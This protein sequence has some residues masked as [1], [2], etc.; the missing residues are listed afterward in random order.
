MSEK[1]SKPRR[2]GRRAGVFASLAAVAS[3]LVTSVAAAPAQGATQT[4]WIPLRCALAGSIPVAVGASLTATVPNTVAPGGTFNIT[5]TT[6]EVIFPGTAQQSAAVFGANAIQGIVT[7]FQTHLVNA[8]SAFVTTAGGNPAQSS[9]TQ[10]NAVGA[11]QPPNQ[12][13]VAG[14]SGPRINGGDTSRG[15]FLP[16]TPAE[17]FSFGDVP[18]DTTGNTGNRYGPAP[19]VGGGAAPGAGTPD[20]VPDLGPLTVTG[21]AG[22]DVTIS[23]TNPGGTP[24]VGAGI[25]QPRV[26]A[27]AIS[28][29]QGGSPGTYT[30]QL[31]ADCAFDNRAPDTTV[32]EPGGDEVGDDGS[33]PKPDPTWVDAFTIPIEDVTPPEDGVGTASARGTDPDAIATVPGTGSFPVSAQF[34]AVTNCDE[35]A[36]TR[37]FIAHVQTPLNVTITR[38]STQTST[39]HSEG[40]TSVNEGTGTAN[41][42]GAITDT[43]TFTWRFEESP[44]TVDIDGTTTGGAELH[45]SGAPQPLSGTPGGV[46]VFGTLPWPAGGG[47]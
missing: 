42:T 30:T 47:V 24:L 10:F 12:P 6:T 46:W 33:V 39:C 40:G 18:A 17:S 23:N 16:A 45:I 44:D 13:A 5:G 4:A 36:N 22:Q 1:L 19:G 20:T 27:N 26:V 8:T 38:T 2:R 37:P 3:I 25:N 14:P 32:N 28:F 9:P 31:P 43:A 21:A 41:V 35:N 15:G 29:H 7:Q 11:V 34:S